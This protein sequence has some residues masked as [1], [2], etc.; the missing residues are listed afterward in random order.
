MILE[1]NLKK[2][3]LALSAL[4]LAL[5]A[6]LSACGGGSSTYTI[7]GTVA[8]LEYPGLILS[9]NGEDLPVAPNGRETLPGSTVSTPKNVT[10]SFTKQLDYG[11]TYDVVIKQMPQHQICAPAQG[12]RTGDT[13]G[14]LAV[15]DAV[16]VCGLVSNPVSGTVT[17]LTSGEL[18]LTNGSTAMVVP[19]NA[20]STAISFAFPEVTYGQTYGITILRQPEGFTCTVSNGVG[21]MGDNPVTNVAVACRQNT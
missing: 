5:A 10:Y 12:S 16:F 18:R 20:T 6:G 17:G 8:G 15:I 19:G 14:R 3:T 13:A 7:G 9:N 4:T 2:S 21:E 11:E 1:T